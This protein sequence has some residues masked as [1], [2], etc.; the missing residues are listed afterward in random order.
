MLRQMIFLESYNPKLLHKITY[1]YFVFLCGK[2][3]IH[4]NKLLRDH[5]APDI[6]LGSED[7]KTVRPTLKALGVY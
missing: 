3:F 6:V 7:T 2:V 4:K 1:I 5:Y